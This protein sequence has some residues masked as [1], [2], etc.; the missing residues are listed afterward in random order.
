MRRMLK[1]AKR[2]LKDAQEGR[3][4]RGMLG[5]VGECLV[6]Q[7]GCSGLQGSAWC[8]KG[9]AGGCFGLQGDA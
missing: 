5:A 6:W 2:M 7:G 9:A 3:S 4:C 8:G 1:V